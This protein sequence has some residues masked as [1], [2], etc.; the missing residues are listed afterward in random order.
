MQASTLFFPILKY[1]ESL[2]QY[3]NLV[4]QNSSV[5][6]LVNDILKISSRLQENTKKW[7]N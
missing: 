6:F 3:V 7:K 2:L 1:Q 4:R 5:S